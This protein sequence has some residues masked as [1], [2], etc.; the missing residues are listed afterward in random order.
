MAPSPIPCRL[1][2]PWV[3]PQQQARLVCPQVTTTFPEASLLVATRRTKAAI[4]MRTTSEW[5][6]SAVVEHLPRVMLLKLP[7]RAGPTVAQHRHYLSQLLFLL[8]P[9]TLGTQAHPT[10]RWASDQARRLRRPYNSLRH[11]ITH[12]H[13]SPMQQYHP[14]AHGPASH[15]LYAA[16]PGLMAPPAT[17]GYGF[18]QPGQPT[19][20]GQWSYDG[21]AVQGGYPRR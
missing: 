7:L 15:D 4:T 14:S 8:M 13:A 6:P 3:V 2:L 20:P 9:R 21:G 1:V 16:Q 10:P 11:H 12:M 5:V 19:A 18:G 17:P